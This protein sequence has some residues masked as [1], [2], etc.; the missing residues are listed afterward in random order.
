MLN[1]FNWCVYIYK[2]KLIISE[3]NISIYI[4]TRI[5]CVFVQQHNN[6][7]DDRD[8]LCNNIILRTCNNCMN[9]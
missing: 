4:I 3:G 7:A 6:G 5:R 2:T 9:K 1:V 8:I